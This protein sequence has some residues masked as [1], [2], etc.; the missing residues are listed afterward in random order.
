[1]WDASLINVFT[2]L[3]ERGKSGTKFNAYEPKTLSA[4]PRKLHVTHKRYILRSKLYVTH[5][6]YIVYGRNGNAH[7]VCTHEST[8]IVD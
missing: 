8:I 3:M 1:M 7:I 2:N 5:K 4:M 6:R